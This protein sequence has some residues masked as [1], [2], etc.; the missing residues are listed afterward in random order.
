MGV[1]RTTLWIIIFCKNEQKPKILQ[2]KLKEKWYFWPRGKKNV[3][4]T[5]HGIENMNEKIVLNFFKGI[6]KMTQ[7]PKIIPFDLR[8]D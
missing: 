6:L 3:G 7:V 8:I 2:S 5:L 4:H 1:E